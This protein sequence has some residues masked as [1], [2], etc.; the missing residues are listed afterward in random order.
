MRYAAASRLPWVL[1]VLLTGASALAQEAVLL[2]E[3]F[4]E[5]AGPRVQLHGANQPFEQHALEITTAKAHSGTHS[6][7]IDYGYLHGLQV[8]LAPRSN[9]TPQVEWGA[10]GGAGTFHLP[11]LDLVL[12]PDRGYLLTVYVWVEQA[13]AQN[14][15]QIE[16]EMLTASDAG[17]V[18]TAVL[19]DPPISAPTA[20]WV[21]VEQEL[22]ST[23]IAQLEAG[24]SNTADLRLNSISLNSFANGRYRLTAYADDLEVREVPLPTVAESRRQAAAAAGPKPQFRA[25]PAVE[26]LFVW[27]V[28][29]GIMEPGPD[30]FRAYDRTAGSDIRAQQAARVR[31]F[32]EWA[33][34]DLRRH[35]CNLLIQGGGMLFPLEEQS[36]YDYVQTCLDECAR[37]GIKFAP[38]TYLTQH[39]SSQASREQCE[40]AMRKAVGQFGKHPALLAYW[41]VDEP[42]AATADDFYWGKQTLEA[43]DPEH[44]A[45]CTC[46]SI[47]SIRTF[48]D[49]LPILCIDYYP[50]A[51]VPW[52]DKGA[53][54][55]GDSAR[56]ARELGAQR[57]W[58]LPQVFGQSSWRAPSAPEFLIQVFS[59]LAEGATGFAP[60]AYADRPQWHDPVNEYGHLVDPYGN[61]SPAW[62]QMRRLGPVL[63]S[64]GALLAGAQRLPDE[65]A[66][67]QI[68][69]SVVSAVGRQRPG[70]VARA[71]HDAKRQARYVVVYNNAP[72][73]RWTFPVALAEIA[74]DE[75]VLDLFALRAVPRAGNT[76]SVFLE[77]GDGRLYA[78]GLPAALAAIG[79]EVGANRLA[80]ERDLLELEVQVAQRQ[81]TETAAVATAVTAA[82]TLADLA[83]A[84]LTLEQ[85][86][87]A[88]TTAWAV[89]EDIESSR[90][91]LGRSNALL[92][93]RVGDTAFPRDAPDVKA[94]TERMISLSERFYTLQ[95]R[96]LRG[97]APD[98]APAA[99]A[100]REDVERQEAAVRGLLGG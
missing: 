72:A 40:A 91:A 52:Y 79:A 48:A 64:A 33:L 23:L 86:Q 89:Q 5:P 63:R 2:Q 46:N 30:W 54:A 14:P 60:Y 24:G 19:L 68:S 25:I 29:G 51:P 92:C 43:L 18:R 12:R 67:A 31:E 77:P 84:R 97:S 62:E 36:A 88:D 99:R 27:G 65:A 82:S 50:M 20:G 39:Y 7:K 70:A 45:L 58:M 81:G 13:S 49:R 16:V 6:L 66:V 98:L 90:G 94:L 32:S 93:R 38:S 59:S 15:L 34:L 76:F 35:H 22:T 3:G 96:W 53:W 4:E 71:F 74:D 11:G 26:N 78:V 69:A 75:R 8:Y 17:P 95:A 57:I 56:Y 83:S 1:G 28:Y 10:L 100:L 85:Q 9:A 21:K 37:Y 87:R 42:G 80:L 61:P 44:P 73:Y 55:V 41:L 47:S